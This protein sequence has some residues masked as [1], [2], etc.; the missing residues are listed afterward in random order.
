MLISTLVCVCVC[1]CVCEGVCVSVL[2]SMDI[3][4]DESDNKDQSINQ[5]MLAVINVHLMAYLF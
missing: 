3:Y 5:Y 2:Y 4:I 1:V